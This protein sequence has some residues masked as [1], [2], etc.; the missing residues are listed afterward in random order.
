MLKA[1]NCV[2]L[3][4]GYN[5]LRE[6]QENSGVE[7]KTSESLLINKVFHYKEI[8]QEESS[9]IVWKPP[10][11][12]CRFYH[13]HADLETERFKIF[14]TWICRLEYGDKW[15]LLLGKSKLNACV[16]RHLPRIVEVFVML[17]DFSRQLWTTI[18]NDFPNS[19]VFYIYSMFF[20]D[21]YMERLVDA[22]RKATHILQVHC[23]WDA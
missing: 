4:Q 13:P 11:N 1:K 5:P 17:F 6:I 15:N 8:S 10:F 3:D 16:F 20:S 7:I 14:T 23:G 2:T 18:P 19:M 21:N 22:C 9:L 12:L